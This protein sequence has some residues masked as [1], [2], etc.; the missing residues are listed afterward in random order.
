MK[1]CPGSALTLHLWCNVNSCTAD[2]DP[3]VNAP[4]VQYDRGKEDTDGDQIA[5]VFK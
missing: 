3:H 5:D 2:T 1:F 4:R